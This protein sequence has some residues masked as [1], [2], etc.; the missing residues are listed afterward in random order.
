MCIR[1][2]E[3]CGSLP[4]RVFPERLQ[5]A[6]LWNKGSETRLEHSD[7]DADSVTHASPLCHCL[8]CPI[9]CSP[10]FPTTRTSSEF[11]REKNCL[12][13]SDLSDPIAFLTGFNVSRFSISQDESN[14]GEGGRRN[15]LGYFF[16]VTAAGQEIRGQK[17]RG[18]GGLKDR[19]PMWKKKAFI[20]RHN[21]KSHTFITFTSIYLTS[22]WPLFRYG[23]AN[24]LFLLPPHGHQLEREEA[25]SSS[26][27]HNYWLIYPQTFLPPS[28]RHRRPVTALLPLI[29][30][31]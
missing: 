16:P 21:T 23:N 15:N 27:Q 12:Q 18:E 26:N 13:W 3:H 19:V 25:Q 6:S 17:E 1:F 31:F 5:Q 11:Q 29:S 24:F 30:H 4:A 8:T 22:F 2:R 9:I 10:S 14:Q 7:N 20:Q 28:L